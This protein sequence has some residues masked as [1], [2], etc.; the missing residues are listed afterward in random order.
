M[1]RRRQGVL[2]MLLVHPGG[3][4]WKNKD[5]GAWTLPRGAVEDGEDYFV[6]AQREF[7]EE[8]G[9]TSS[10][11]YHSLGE[12]KHKS[13]KRVHVWAFEGDCD[14]AAIMSNTFEMEWPPKSGH[15][16]E[17]PEIDRAQFFN[18]VEAREKML[19][20]ET[21]LI[22]RLSHMFPDESKAAR[23]PKS[24]DMPTLFDV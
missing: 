22:E 6:A 8:T 19:P 3:P 2:E 21:P 18:V 7:T 20:A 5:V 17:F 10:G 24:G 14:P 11:P 23:S 9:I 4:F 16:L 15:R 13:G 12:V 1:Y